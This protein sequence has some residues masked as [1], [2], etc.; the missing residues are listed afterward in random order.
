MEVNALQLEN[1]CVATV[2]AEST[3]TFFKLVQPLKALLPTV[4]IRGTFAVSNAVQLLNTL[5]TKVAHFGA[6]IDFNEVQL[7]KAP[8]LNAVTSGIYA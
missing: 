5:L 8:A 1:A 3:F 2:F 4:V 7:A 6:S